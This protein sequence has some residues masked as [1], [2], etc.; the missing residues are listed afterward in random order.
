MPEPLSIVANLLVAVALV[1]RG[2]SWAGEEAVV[3][4]SSAP[5]KK[6]S[7]H[8][9]DLGTGVLEPRGDVPLGGAPGPQFLHP[10]GKRL[11][12]SL[13]STESVAAFRVDRKT[14][15]LRPIRTS[16]IDLNATYIAADRSGRWLLAV[17]YRD[18]KVATY[19][20]ADDGGVVG[21]PVSVFD[22]HRCAHAILA[23]KA[24]RFVLVPHTCANAVYQFRF[25]AKT[26]SLTPNDPARVEPAVGLE[27][28]HLAFHP[29]LDVIYFD[30]EVGS[31]VTAYRYDRE[32]GSVVP[33]QTVSTLPAGFSDK[34]TCADLELTTDGR[35]VYASNRGHNSIAGFS[36]DPKDGRL[37]AIGQ[38]GTGDTPRSFNLSP[39]D[40]WIVVAGQRSNDLTVHRRDTANG[41]LQKV[42]VH[43]T[44]AGPAWVEIVGLKK[45][46]AR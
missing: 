33:F 45:R 10:D 30:D 44:G 37:T 17:S 12:V 36:A 35:F 21:D 42:A 11:Y 34:N 16:G 38:F 25:D 32:R 40:R 18:G 31:S 41:T 5:Q 39:N 7:V 6:L 15:A 4:V 26:G 22:T 29:D 20:I 28:R 1:G 9:L 46:A 43:P 2:T 19:R 8:V 23:D 24:N 14:G 3:F 27:P 13:R